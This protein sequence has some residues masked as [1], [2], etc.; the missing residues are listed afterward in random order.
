MKQEL[1]EP[2]REKDEFTVPAGDYSL[3]VMDWSSS[4]KISEDWNEL[5]ITINQHY[6]IDIYRIIH[7]ATVGMNKLPILHTCF[8]KNRSYSG[9]TKHI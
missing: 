9:A 1:T 6:L 8:H 2:Q 3:L 5:N 4:E 7:S